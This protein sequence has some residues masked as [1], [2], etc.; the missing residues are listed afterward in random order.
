MALAADYVVELTQTTGSGDITLSGV[1]TAD[2]GLFRDAFGSGEVWY[3][4]KNLDNRENGI[5]T[6]DGNNTL[7]RTTVH[8][9]L[10]NG[11]Y[12]NTSP[13][14]INLQAG[15][16]LVACTMNA[17]AF[18]DFAQAK[19]V[20]DH[21]EGT[22]NRHLA[23]AIDYDESVTGLGANVQLA[24]DELD[25][26]V[27]LRSTE[28][29]GLIDGGGITKTGDTTIDVTAGAAELIDGYTDRPAPVAENVTC[30]ENKS[31]KHILKIMVENLKIN[32]F[33]LVG[34]KT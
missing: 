7:V 33:R 18:N 15:G 23:D 32:K 34:V 25:K 5:G 1:P 8:S 6:F 24:L 30:E 4:L 11:V 31:E 26:S 20:I 21:A 17:D 29:S 16:T 27:G 3:S 9:T 14:A 19:D 22:A 2:F 13:S 28:A 10:V 12:N